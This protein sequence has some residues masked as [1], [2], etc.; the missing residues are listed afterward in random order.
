M[1]SKLVVMCSIFL[2]GTVARDN[3]A[4]ACSIT[5]ADT[6]AVDQQFFMCQGAPNPLPDP[7]TGLMDPRPSIFFAP[8][9][10]PA[11]A[12]PPGCNSPLVIL[13]PI[14]AADCQVMPCPNP[15][16]LQGTG[17]R[18]WSFFI[19][20]D[21]RWHLDN[22]EWSGHG[23]SDTVFYNPNQPYSK[24]LSAAYLAWFGL[25]D[26]E[27]RMLHGTQDYVNLLRANDSNDW[28]SKYFRSMDLGTDNLG[29]WS[30]ST[31]IIG[32]DELAT[33]CSLYD[34]AGKANNNLVFRLDTN[35][36]EAWHAWE[37]G[38]IHFGSISH[39]AKQGSCSVDGGCDPFYSHPLETFHPFGRL[40]EA[41]YAIASPPCAPTRL[42]AII[43]DPKKF[44][45]PTQV[46]W[47]FM[48]DLLASPA[49]WVTNDILNAAS[50]AQG[51]DT[52][53]FIQTPP[54]D[55]GVMAPI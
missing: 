7:I 47:E 45:S 4:S 22:N 54:F 14:P 11:T 50:A 8:F 27:T 12:P 29:E 51:L 36:H 52:Q 19:Q 15:A 33:S 6:D 49:D 37:H 35:L 28:H 30:L 3:G 32:D 1:R 48:C 24:V 16:V 39:K 17:L 55:C 41:G 20:D 40:H 10:R 13:P 18:Q 42:C 53:Y 38:S 26:D 46:E 44:H 34:A 23:K 21:D 2:A 31:T 43:I 25:K 5:D 9:G